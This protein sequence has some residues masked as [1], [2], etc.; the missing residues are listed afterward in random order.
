MII[1]EQTKPKFEPAPA[2]ISQEVFSMIVDI[3][4][5]DVKVLNSKETKKKRQQ[6]VVW[7]LPHETFKTAAGEKRRTISRPFNAT[8]HKKSGFRAVLESA[9]GKPFTDAELAAGVDTNKFIG[10]NCQLNI[11]HNTV[12]GNTYANISNVV[13]LGKGMAPQVLEGQPLTYDIPE[14]GD[15]ELPE[16]MPEW[17]KDKIKDSD[18]WKARHGVPDVGGVGSEEE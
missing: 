8:M 14:T 10:L 11:I 15:I 18:E 2:G 6:L 5:H 9:R 12:G 17:I 4:T 3:G 1:K 13:P 7:E 16:A